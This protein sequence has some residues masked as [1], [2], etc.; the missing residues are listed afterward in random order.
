MDLFHEDRRILKKGP[1]FH[2]VTLSLTLYAHLF[3]INIIGAVVLLE[4]DILGLFTLLFLPG[5]VITIVYHKALW[6]GID[7]YDL[8]TY[9]RKV[10][11][12]SILT[13]LIILYGL[14][15]NYIIAKKIEIPRIL[16]ILV[17]AT[18]VTPIWVK[19]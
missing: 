16:L 13:L 18:F 9:K 14:T 11:Y 5:I 15:V 10:S 2:L 7:K 8:D 3:I 19:V 12:L 6:S 1:L 4:N 17:V